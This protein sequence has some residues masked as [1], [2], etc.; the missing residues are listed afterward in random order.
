[1]ATIP[2]GW[3]IRHNPANREEEENNLLLLLGSFQKEKL[4]Q[5]P[6]PPPLSSEFCYMWSD[7]IPES[8]NSSSM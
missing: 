5:L 1:M 3:R 8:I 6:P 7:P 4:K 2:Y